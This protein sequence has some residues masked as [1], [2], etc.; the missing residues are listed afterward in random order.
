MSS[1]KRHFLLENSQTLVYKR[2]DLFAEGQ[3]IQKERAQTHWPALLMLGSGT[4]EG[5]GVRSWFS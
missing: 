1:E 4:A 3:S 2:K 5:V